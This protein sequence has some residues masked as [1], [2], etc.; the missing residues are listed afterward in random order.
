MK[1]TQGIRIG[2]ETINALTFA[3]DI[4]FYAET[5][6]DLQNILTNVN[7]ILWDSYRMKLNKKKDKN[8]GVQQNKAYPA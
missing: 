2:G 6:E 1:V 3:D 5:E 7:K 4:A 8:N